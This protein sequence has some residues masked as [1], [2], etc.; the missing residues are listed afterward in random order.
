MKSHA[1]TTRKLVFA[2]VCL[3]LGMVLPFLTGQIP[4]I[5]SMLL[6]MHIR[7]CWPALSAAVLLAWRSVSSLPLLRNLAL[8]MPPRAPRRWRWLSRWR[9]TAC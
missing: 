8:M 9:P 3:A 4:A 5:G 7:F 2:A 1:L 6:P